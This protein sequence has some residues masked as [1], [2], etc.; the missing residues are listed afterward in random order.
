[1]KVGSSGEETGLKLEPHLVLVSIALITALG[2]RG[3]GTPGPETASGDHQE[4][5][6]ASAATG[7]DFESGGQAQQDWFRLPELPAVGD[8]DERY[9]GAG[10]YTYVETIGIIS[11]LG[12]GRWE[13]P[14]SAAA[15]DG[16][17]RSLSWTLT[18]SR[19]DDAFSFQEIATFAC[20]LE[21]YTNRRV[22][23]RVRLSRIDDSEAMLWRPRLVVA[24]QNGDFSGAHAYMSNLS[25]L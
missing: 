21:N 24:E 1:M 18:P 20:F 19:G 4:G 2:C 23:S 3:P 15:S 5:H 7:D 6:S 12:K 13:L 10:F 8:R 25:S 16:E 22:V 17:E 14:A 9:A 11:R